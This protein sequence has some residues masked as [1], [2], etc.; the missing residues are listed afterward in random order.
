MT[1]TATLTQGYELYYASAAAVATKI[2][3]IQSAP[4]PVGGARPQLPITTLDSVEEEFVGALPSPSKSSFEIVF[5]EGDATHVALLGLKDSGA[6]KPWALGSS[7][8]TVSPT[9]SASVFV[10]TAVAR[11]FHYFSAYVEDMVL[12][13]PANNVVKGTI[14]LQRSGRTTT[15]AHT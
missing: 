5:N 3:Q 11:T 9:V 10:T 7:D 1:V 4:S 13:I 15:V 14:T 12:S 2:T 6:V 8:G